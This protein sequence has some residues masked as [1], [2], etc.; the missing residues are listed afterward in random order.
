MHFWSPGIFLIF[1]LCCLSKVEFQQ[2]KVCYFSTLPSEVLF[3]GRRNRA[4]WRQKKACLS[5]MA[6]SL[7][8]EVGMCFSWENRTSPLLK[9]FRVV[10][11]I[12][13]AGKAGIRG[14]HFAS[15]RHFFF[16]EE[17]S[18]PDQNSERVS[19]QKDDGTLPIFYTK[20]HYIRRHCAEIAKSTK[21]RVRLRMAPV[22][23]QASPFLLCKQRDSGRDR[24]SE[25]FLS[26]V[27]FFCFYV[28]NAFWWICQKKKKGNENS[29]FHLPWNYSDQSAGNRYFHRKDK[30]TKDQNC[31]FLWDFLPYF[32]W[33]VCFC[34]FFQFFLKN[35]QK[36]ILSHS[37]HLRRCKVSKDQQFSSIWTVPS[38][39]IPLREQGKIYFEPSKCLWWL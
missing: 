33:K 38:K 15:S 35:I 14:G 27:L 5:P 1:W 28:R 23:M 9:C 37:Y 22:R 2:S 36:L 13:L 39:A 7:P 17:D 34:Y 18:L 8:M 32:C 29:I 20:L 19:H 31:P 4:D 11:R 16:L 24:E 25:I 30:H 26:C 12:S 3:L 6:M 10:K 21:Q